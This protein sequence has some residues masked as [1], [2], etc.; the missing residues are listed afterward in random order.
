MDTVWTSGAQLSKS[1][2]NSLKGRFI[3]INHTIERS[4]QLNIVKLSNTKLELQAV[5]IIIST[6]PK[7]QTRKIKPE[8]SAAKLK[9]GRKIL[10][11][12]QHN[13]EYKTYKNLTW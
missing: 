10:V 5:G 6:K 3:A 8:G 1:A 2:D 7:A 12:Q 9:A 4:I 11:I 13:K